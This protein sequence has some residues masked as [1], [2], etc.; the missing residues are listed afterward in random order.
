[1]PVGTVE[2]ACALCDNPVTESPYPRHHIVLEDES[3]K[4]PNQRAEARLCEDCWTDVCGELSITSS[5]E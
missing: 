5:P 4:A 1:M 3:D 2:L